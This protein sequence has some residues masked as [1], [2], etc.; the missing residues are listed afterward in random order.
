MAANQQIKKLIEA[1]KITPNAFASKLGIK[2]TSVYNI[3]NNKNKPSYDLLEKIIETFSVNPNWILQDKGEIFYNKNDNSMRG[4]FEGGMRGGDENFNNSEVQN[5]SS[6]NGDFEPEVKDKDRYTLLAQIIKTNKYE[7]LTECY[8]N[9]Y[10]DIKLLDLYLETYNIECN[11]MH[12]IENF[13]K[14]R[15]EM[16]EVMRY[17]KDD[18]KITK[19][20][21]KIIEPYADIIKEL[22][23]KVSEFDKTKYRLFCLDD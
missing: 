9:I 3:L 13:F 2:A 22:H 12:I 14:K 1:L 18:I 10:L 5:N 15:A 8:R 6:K 17:F 7:D 16:D 21:Y 19:E 20:L 11:M 4:Y 23:N